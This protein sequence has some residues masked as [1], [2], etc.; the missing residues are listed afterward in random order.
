MKKKLLVIGLSLY[1]AATMVACGGH[2]QK[3]IDLR[4]QGVEALDAGDYETA[5]K[6]FWRAQASGKKPIS[7]TGTWALTATP[8]KPLL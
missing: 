5:I 2:S 7:S 3:E 8:K 6:L 1:I 4:D